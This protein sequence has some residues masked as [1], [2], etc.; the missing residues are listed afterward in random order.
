[1]I[2][3]LVRLV[4]IHPNFRKAELEALATLAGV[5]LDIVVYD[6]SVSIH[7]TCSS[8]YKPFA[9]LNVSKIIL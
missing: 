4:Q 5:S 8:F 7:D 2:E 3:Y 9:G 6:E 1:M